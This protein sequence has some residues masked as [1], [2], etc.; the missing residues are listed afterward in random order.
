MSNELQTIKIS[1][2]DRERNFCEDD[3]HRAGSNLK[4][5]IL[6]TKENE[7]DEQKP[8]NENEFA[9]L[10]AVNTLCLELGGLKLSSSAIKMIGDCGMQK[11][12][13][14]RIYD[15]LG[16]NDEA[17]KLFGQRFGKNIAHL[18]MLGNTEV[19]NVGLKALIESIGNL[20]VL[21]LDNAIGLLSERNGTI[22][23]LRHVWS[24]INGDELDK[25]SQFT[26]KYAPY[27]RHLD[28]TM[29]NTKEKTPEFIKI[30]ENLTGLTKL[31][32]TCTAN[33]AIEKELAQLLAKL[34]TNLTNVNICVWM[35]DGDVL[36]DAIGKLSKL[37]QLT[38]NGR[39]PMR[40]IDFRINKTLA[41][42]ANM[43]NLKNL[44]LI[45]KNHSKTLLDKFASNLPNL[46]TLELEGLDI[47]DQ[48]LTNL[49]GLNNLSFLDIVSPEITDIGMSTLVTKLPNLTFLRV[50]DFGTDKIWNKTLDAIVGEASRRQQVPIEIVF[51]ETCKLDLESRRNSLP[52]NLTVS[53][54]NSTHL[55]SFP[56]S[57]PRGF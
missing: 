13:C 39:S 10:S 8:L 12:Q 7:L 55:L 30:L 19:T 17:V 50:N 5:L 44:R 51:T 23:N 41:P 22:T 57:T 49:A 31:S 32:I 46:E 47:D 15:C 33:V 24:R 34:A 27:L 48:A 56:G 3:Q 54:R 4:D 38:L 42:M 20:E 9:K 25:L 16:I 6:F 40:H 2:S 43:K 37:E 52:K 36:I 26:V 18:E 29:A 14:L 35:G 45:L 21:H 1:L 28:I 11:L 53:K